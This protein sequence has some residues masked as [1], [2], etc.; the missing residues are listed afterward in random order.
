M[1]N[2]LKEEADTEKPSKIFP[3]I[4]VSLLCL[5]KNLGSANN[6]FLH[7]L[8]AIKNIDEPSENFKTIAEQFK[9]KSYIHNPDKFSQMVIN[10]SKSLSE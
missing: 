9:H 4:L 7:C 5:Y 8:S 3:M 10:Y 6:K 2:F 1:W